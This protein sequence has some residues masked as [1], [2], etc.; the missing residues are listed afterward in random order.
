MT[1]LTE[2]ASQHIVLCHQE[3]DT[4]GFPTPPLQT[5]SIA[6]YLASRQTTGA[7]R[8]TVLD[9]TSELEVIAMLDA[10]V[11]AE[12]DVVGLSVCM[13][14]APKMYAL[15]AA[16]KEAAPHVYL[17]LGGPQMWLDDADMQQLLERVPA[18][19]VIRGEGE[20]SM[21]ELLDVPPEQRPRG[22]VIAGKSVRHLDEIGG[23]LLRDWPPDPAAAA[24]AV[25]EATRGCKYPCSFCANNLPGRT[26]RERSDALMRAEL[27][28]AAEIGAKLIMHLYAYLNGPPERTMHRLAQIEAADLP[29]DISHTFPLDYF[30]LTEPEVA[31]IARLDAVVDMGLQ[32]TTRA[33]LR[34]SRRGFPR[35][36][37]ESSLAWCREHGVPVTVELILGLPG[38]GFDDIMRTLDYMSGLEV[39]FVTPTLIVLPG[40]ELY[41]KRRELGLVYDP[42]THEL[43]RSPYLSEEELQRVAKIARER[44]QARPSPIDEA[45][46]SAVE[47]ATAGAAT[48]T[49][50]GTLR[51]HGGRWSL[52]TE[53]GEVIGVD[54]ALPDEMVGVQV[55][56]RGREVSSSG[57]RSVTLEHVEPT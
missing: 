13:W 57:G 50:R 12:P 9:F 42:D 11:A 56:I 14:N 21:Y 23:P 20:V 39:G 10:V 30:T 17:V 25:V 28:A 15:A 49:F 16:L 4:L 24:I 22:T 52:E 6:S 34:Y 38:D 46:R 1:P 37:F 8:I 19:V 5:R 40:T 26:V 55:E 32:T 29:D 33:A 44:K 31:A 54:G 3:S 48:G 7:C 2:R 35:Q 53:Q 43:I 36:Q 47:R 18:D 27:R 45:V 51:A 41:L